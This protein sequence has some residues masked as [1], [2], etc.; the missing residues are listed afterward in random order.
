MSKDASQTNGSGT[1]KAIMTTQRMNRRD[2]NSMSRKIQEERKTKGE[3]RM[4]TA[5]HL[6]DSEAESSQEEGREN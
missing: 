1:A 4:V 6:D 3:R 2:E 5:V